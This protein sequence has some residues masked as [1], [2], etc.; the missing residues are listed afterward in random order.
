MT[1][2][3]QLDLKYTSTFVSSHELAQ[4]S[5]FAQVAYQDLLLKHEGAGNEFHGWLDLPETLDQEEYSQIKKVAQSLR[6]DVDV[7]VVIGIG[8]SY[9]GAKAALQVLSPYFKSKEEGPE[10][11]FAGMQLSGQYHH[12]LL[13][14][15]A[16]KRF[17]INVISKSGTTTEPAL[18]FRIFRKE[19][20]RRLGVEEASKYIVATTDGK[21]GKL[22]ELA[23][24]KGYQKF[25]VP[26]DVGGRYSV[27]TAVGLFPLQF[28]GIDTDALI[29][30]AKG[31][32]K[33]MARPFE[34]NACLQYAALRNI[35]YNKGYNTEILATYEPKFSY[36]SEWWKQ[37]FG[38]SEGKDQ[39]GIFPTSVQFTT[40]LHSLGQYIQDGRRFLFETTILETD[41]QTYFE[42]EK[43]EGNPDNLNYLEGKSMAEINAKAAEGTI[44]AHV[45]G[46]VPN[47]VLNI[48]QLNAKS[49]G[50]LL[51]F[52][53][54]ACGIS[55]YM[56][57]VNPFDQPG[58]EAYKSNMFKLLGKPGA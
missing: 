58:V 1:S 21:K 11:I 25:V 39:K 16:N 14:Y 40:D 19:L 54:C 17:A 41:P 2:S 31:A 6:K 5:K 12:Q 32:K 4:S 23:T 22:Y 27:L 3:V 34:E 29:E 38:E 43:I 13:N 51:Y 44:Q 56:S 28:A 15:L 33:D 45:S 30:G 53:E 46:G 48:T 57:N 36:L 47:I 52:F 9:L 35:L 8:G 24:Q 50:Y 55:A 7:L 18:A 49:L 20:E 42:I 26:D 10:I 37:L